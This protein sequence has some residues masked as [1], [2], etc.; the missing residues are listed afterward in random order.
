MKAVMLRI[1]IDSGC[2]GI[3]GPLFHDGSFEFIPVPKYSDVQNEE[4]DATEIMEE[5]QKNFTYLRSPKCLDSLGKDIG[6]KEK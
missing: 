4:V 5:L 6:H 3:Q 2:G 1:G